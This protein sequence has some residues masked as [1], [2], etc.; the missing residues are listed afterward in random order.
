LNE[1]Y[2]KTKDYRKKQ[3]KVN[4]DKNKEKINVRRRELNQLKKEQKI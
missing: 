1:S 3:S 2:Y 4:Y